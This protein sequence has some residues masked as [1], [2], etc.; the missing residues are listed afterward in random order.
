MDRVSIHH[1]GHHLFVRAEV[2]SHH[3]HLRA[4]ERDH[5]LRVTARQPLQ[6]T[7]G[8]LARL[9]GN[10]A[11]GAAVGQARQCALP[12]HPHRQRR[13]FPQGDVGMVAQPALGGAE[14]QVMLDAVAGENLS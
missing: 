2:G 3:V 7:G 11:F 12:A 6:L 1:P 14:R 9:A 5:L 10:A 4:D 13:H 8:H